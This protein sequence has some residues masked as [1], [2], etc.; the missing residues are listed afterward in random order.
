MQQ[1]AVNLAANIEEL[2]SGLRAI[3][4]ITRIRILFVLSHGEINVSELMF[5]LQQSQPRV[6]RHL[7]V[8]TEAGLISRHKEGNWVLFR[9]REHGL[10]GVLARAIVEMLPGAEMVLAQDI[11]RLDNVRT[12]RSENA[13]TY[14]AHNAEDWENLRALHVSEEDVEA[15]MKAMIGDA[16]IANLVDL[17]TGTGRV[18]EL[19]SQLSKTITGID[20]SREMLA[21]ARTNLARRGIRHA[22]IRQSDLYALPLLDGAADM[23]TIHQVLHFLDD[24]LQALLE[25]RRILD[26]KGRMLVVDFAPHELEDLREKH[27][28]RRLGISAEQMTEWL[29][30]AS[31]KLDRHIVLQPPWRKDGLGLT[32]S[33]WL[34]SPAFETVETTGQLLQSKSHLFGTNS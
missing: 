17:G 34:A 5:I 7:K 29:D 18:I 6:S 14:F 9:L 21:I 26:P 13:A 3:A 8:M 22:Q 25:A 31:F 28:H 1:P 16:P 4:E 19:F 15:Q 27:A 32:V 10:G 23:V 2:L 12:Q 20:L 24:P 30:K 11:E 33:L